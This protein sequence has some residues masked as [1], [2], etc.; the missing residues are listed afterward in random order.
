MTISK[1]FLWF[2]LIF[3]LLNSNTTSVLLFDT[4]DAPSIQAYDCIYYTN[5]TAA[6]NETIPYCIRTQE[7]TLLNRSFVIR[8]CENSGKEWTFKSLK[9]MNVSPNEVLKW[10]SSIEMVDKYAAYFT[11]G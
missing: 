6:N 4:E 10:N 11:T 1:R 7:S 5:I 9:E 2:L 3:G 8:T